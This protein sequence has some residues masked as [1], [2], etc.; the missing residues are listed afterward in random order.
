MFKVEFRVNQEFLQ[1]RIQNSQLENMFEDIDS[2][3]G[4]LM[5][6]CEEIDKDK[7]VEFVVSG[8]GE[9]SW[10]TDVGTD[11]PV[12]LEQLP[13]VFYW[14]NSNKEDV[15]LDFY[16]QGL[17]RT[18]HFKKITNEVEI[19][20]ESWGTWQPHPKIEHAKL[21]ELSEMFTQTASSFTQ[22]SEKIFPWVKNNYYYLEWFKGIRP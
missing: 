10:F 12:M 5:K 21:N 7:I 13:A 4:L 1:K 18:L 20:C 2:S 9:C 6:L 19:R 3:E 11:L 17:E 15:Q 14:A 22:L 8:F 16:E